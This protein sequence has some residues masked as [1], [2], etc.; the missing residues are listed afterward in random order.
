[1]SLGQFLLGGYTVTSDDKSIVLTKDKIE[2]L[3]FL[4]RWPDNSIF[5]LQ[6]TV[7][8]QTVSSISFSITHCCF[9]HPSPEV[10]RQIPKNTS[11][12]PNFDV[13]KEISLCPGCAKGRMTQHSFPPTLRR[14]SKPFEL[15]HLDLKSFPTISYHKYCYIIIFLDDYT[16]SG[17][18][19]C[20]TAKSA[21][22]NATQQFL[23]AVETQY[24]TRV[25]QWM[26]DAEEEYK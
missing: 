20:L 18:L 13:S 5:E 24:S 19:T 7:T 4:P 10:L 16:S 11:L 12:P 3:C 6:T 25:Q 2:A 14:D 15:I 17:W 21:A 23:A 9:A 22:I 1:M 26:S 8:A